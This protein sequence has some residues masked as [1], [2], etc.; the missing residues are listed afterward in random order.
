MGGCGVVLVPSESLVM[1]FAAG[2]AD[3][4]SVGSEAV[5]TG[6]TI[7]GLS[8]V[9]CALERLEWMALAKLLPGPLATEVS[10]VFGFAY[11][12]VCNIVGW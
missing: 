9:G 8:T 1:K 4:S 11:L 2:R 5:C 12:E 10:Y 6:P 3:R 7:S